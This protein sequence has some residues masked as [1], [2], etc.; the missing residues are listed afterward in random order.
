[1]QC[2]TEWLQRLASLGSTL[3]RD[4]S[5][6][7]GERAS[8]YGKVALFLDKGTFRHDTFLICARCILRGTTCAGTFIGTPRSRKH[9]LD[10]EYLATIFWYCDISPKITS[11]RNSAETWYIGAHPRP[12]YKAHNFA[13]SHRLKLLYRAGRRPRFAFRVTANNSRNGINVNVSWNYVF[14]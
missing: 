11:G 8:L 12:S 5:K 6:C 1:M 4:R 13:N 3:G 9:A 10:L 2:F 14:V 7:Y